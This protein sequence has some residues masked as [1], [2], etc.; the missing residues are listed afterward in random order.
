MLVEAANAPTT[1]AADEILLKKGLTIVPDV[2]ANS[3]GAIVCDF[4]RTQGLSNY[5]CSLEKVREKLQQ[6][7]VTAYDEAKAKASEFKVSM[8]HGA[9]IN[10][11]TKI[12]AAMIWRGWC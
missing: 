6:R 5:N 2:V 9:W 7:I 3:G 1:P 4:E 8:R 12:R 10:A 11:L